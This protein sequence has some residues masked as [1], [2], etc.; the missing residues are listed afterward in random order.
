MKRIKKGLVTARRKCFDMI[1]APEE[2]QSNLNSYSAP[3]KES[4]NHVILELG[5]NAA[6]VDGERC[7]ETL[8]DSSDVSTK[9]R[10]R[11]GRKGRWEEEKK[12]HDPGCFKDISELLVLCN[13]IQ[14]FE[15]I[16]RSAPGNIGGILEK[17]Q[18]TGDVPRFSKKAN[19]SQFF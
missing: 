18:T 17:L 6:F 3:I 7:T 12:I 13:Y 2:R 11:R 5:R 19:H 10:Q 9:G 16:G 15:R 14:G 4:Q 8:S 1:A